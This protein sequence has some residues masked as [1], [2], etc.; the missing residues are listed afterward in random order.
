MSGKSLADLTGGAGIDSYFFS[1]QFKNVDY[2]E[3][4]EL[5]AELT[6]HNFQQLGANNINVHCTSAEE[7]MA[8]ERDYD[9]IF[10]DPARRDANKNKVF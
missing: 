8:K 5:L 10:L 1:K 6:K 9:A 2:V 3:R 7:Y 4:N